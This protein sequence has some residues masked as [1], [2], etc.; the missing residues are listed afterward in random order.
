MNEW[1]SDNG[2]YRTAPATPDL[3]IIT[4]SNQFSWLA[5]PNPLFLFFSV[6]EAFAASFDYRII[7][8]PLAQYRTTFHLLAAGKISSPGTGNA[9]LMGL[10]CY[11]RHCKPVHQSQSQNCSIFTSNIWSILWKTNILFFPLNT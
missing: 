4:I 2:I 3:L 10:F 1:R 6:L 7:M 11:M 9:N 8:Q 5:M